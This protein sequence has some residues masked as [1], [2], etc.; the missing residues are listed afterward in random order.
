ML[1]VQGMLRDQPLAQLAE[2]EEC[3]CGRGKRENIY[4]DADQGGGRRAG[5]GAG[6]R[7]GCDSAPVT[8][9]F[10][11]SAHLLGFLPAALSLSLLNQL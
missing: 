1:A 7:A 6:A 3:A 4:A 8:P 10:G 9:S 2:E 5:G 11:T